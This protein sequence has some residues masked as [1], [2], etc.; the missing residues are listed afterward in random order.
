MEEVSKNPS[1]LAAET[2]T[3]AATRSLFASSEAYAD[4]CWCGAPVVMQCRSH[5]LHCLER[6][7]YV[8]ICNMSE[9]SSQCI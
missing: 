2:Y 4:D 6:G 8:H 5:S 3:L 9:G 7:A 1:C